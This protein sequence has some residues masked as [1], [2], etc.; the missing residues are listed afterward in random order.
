MT[1]HA[2][3]V[4]A[5]PLSQAV[6]EMSQK[7]SLCN[8]VG[9]AELSRGIVYNSQMV[10]DKGKYLGLQRRINLLHLKLHE[11]YRLLKA[12]P[13]Q[14]F[15]VLGDGHAIPDLSREAIKKKFFPEGRE[16]NEEDM[17][18]DDGVAYC[19]LRGRT[20]LRRI[21]RRGKP[22]LSVLVRRFKHNGTGQRE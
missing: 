15:L 9:L 4:P 1:E 5:G 11:L 22:D 21:Q 14:A 17:A 8:C 6:L 13:A 19:L 7:Y 10:A 18:L 2:Q 3:P 16:G 20:Y 12:E